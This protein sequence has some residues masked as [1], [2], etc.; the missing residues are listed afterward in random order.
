MLLAGLAQGMKRL[1]HI[2]QAH[3]FQGRQAVLSGETTMRLQGKVAAFTGADVRIGRAIATLIAA[4]GAAVAEDGWNTG[5]F[6]HDK[7]HMSTVWRATGL[8][9][10]SSLDAGPT[11]EGGLEPGEVCIANISPHERRKR[12]AA[13]VIQ[14]GVG[15]AILVALIATS[16]ERW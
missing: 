6:N 2:A 9:S 8:G 10:G 16:A 15:L 7:G 11:P 3:P 5:G 13:G 12:L 1:A 4:R 14:F